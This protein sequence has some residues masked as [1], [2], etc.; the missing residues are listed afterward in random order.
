MHA[1]DRDRL[2][3]AFSDGFQQGFVIW[4]HTAIERKPRTCVNEDGRNPPPRRI[5]DGRIR[6]EIVLGRRTDHDTA[7]LVGR[8][9]ELGL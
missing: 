5:G 2:A 8:L 7:P 1:P 9:A 6:D 3:S 4:K